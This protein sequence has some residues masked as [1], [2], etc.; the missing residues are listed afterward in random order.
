MDEEINSLDENNTYE[1]DP[2]PADKKVIGGR[3]VYSVKIDPGGKER[4]K[5]RYVAQGFS[6]ILG[7][8]F[9]ETFAPTVKMSTIRILMQ[10]AVNLD[11][12]VHQMDV[13]TAY[14]N[15]SL[16]EEIYMNQPL[17]YE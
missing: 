6:Q 16:D 5:A 11:L 3:W 10:M 7:S 13:K 12:I 4:Y 2:L 17:G 9:T 15:A 8:E 14:L 1:I